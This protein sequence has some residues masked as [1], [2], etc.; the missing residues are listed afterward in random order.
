M[1]EDQ[2][3][4]PACGEETD[5][6]IIKSGRKN[7]VRCSNCGTAHPIQKER[8]RLANVK[9]IVNRDGVSQ[10]HYMNLPAKMELRVGAEL[11]I[12]DPDKDVVLTEITSLETDRRVENAIASVVKTVWARAID[13]VVLKV[14]VYKNGI[15]RPLNF[16]A[17]GDKI[18]ERGQVLEIEGIRFQ[19]TKIKL[20]RVGFA[21]QAEAKDILRIWGR[22]L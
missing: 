1:P 16:G 10:S 8:E 21:D 11:L 22:E 15:T 19:V 6:A 7:L 12:D 5:Y 3:F 14:S 13:E 20:R 17:V 18:F 2:I 9:I 4:C